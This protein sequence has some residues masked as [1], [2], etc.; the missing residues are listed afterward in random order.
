MKKIVLLLAALFT[1][2]LSTTAFAAAQD[3][4][5]VLNAED[6]AATKLVETLLNNG[7]LS[8]VQ[9]LFHPE[10]KKNFT[11]ANFQALQKDISEKLGTVKDSPR[12]AFWERG[13]KSDAVFYL[14]SFS[15][16]NTVRCAVIF[17]DKNQIV[18][19][20]LTP[21]HPEEKKDGAAK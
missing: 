8:T 13:D 15:K 19:F 20:A 2:A 4:G 18:N 17:D 9:D 16:E 10:F 12:L 5:T 21:I 1:L 14:M 3:N 11:E 6:T 7:S